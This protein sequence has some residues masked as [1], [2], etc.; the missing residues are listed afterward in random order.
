MVNRTKGS[1]ILYDFVY[2]AKVDLDNAIWNMDFKI[3]CR[4][5]RATFVM[6]VTRRKAQ[7]G[8]SQYDLQSYLCLYEG[9]L[10]ITGWVFL[11]SFFLLFIYFWTLLILFIFYLLLFFGRWVRA[12]QPFYDD[13]T[14]IR[15]RG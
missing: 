11:F 5:T 9:M 14:P 15:P 6:A 3:L 12:S 4:N 8:Q 1:D 10:T 2:L 13:F 7:F